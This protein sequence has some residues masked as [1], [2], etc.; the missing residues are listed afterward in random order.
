MNKK[1]T[2]YEKLAEHLD[3]L[4]GGFTPSN[5]GAEYAYCKDC[6]QQKRLNWLPT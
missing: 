4:P 1:E 3:Q 6:S 5:T 2:S